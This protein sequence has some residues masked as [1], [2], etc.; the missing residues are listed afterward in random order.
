LHDWGSASIHGR[1]PESLVSTVEIDE[2]VPLID[3]RRFIMR[4][5][6]ETTE[7]RNKPAPARW[8]RVDEASDLRRI[9]CY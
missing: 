7:V 4:T 2:P 8:T 9:W 5:L 3:R 6:S 1:P